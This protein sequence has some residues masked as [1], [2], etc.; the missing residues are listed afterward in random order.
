MFSSRFLSAH[1]VLIL[2][3]EVVLRDKVGLELKVVPEDVLIGGALDRFTAEVKVVV[4]ARAATGVGRG[5][6][7]GVRA[8]VVDDE[9]AG[10]IV[11]LPGEDGGVEVGER[12][13]ERVVAGGD[14]APETLRRLEPWKEGTLY[15]VKV[16]DFTRVRFVFTHDQLRQIQFRNYE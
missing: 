14:H 11:L 5:R 13:R 12:G 8:A 10:D 2:A 4:G 16:Q 9:L 15:D 1:L 3:N 6:V 7:D